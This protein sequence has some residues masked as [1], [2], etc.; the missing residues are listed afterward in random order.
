MRTL[1]SLFDYTGEWSAPFWHA[2]WDVIQ[3]D[4]QH[5]TDISDFS[6]EYLIDN[7]LGDGTVD[8]VILAPPCTEFTVSGAR[9]WNDK[10]ADGRTAAAAELVLQGI[11][12]I[13]F[14]KPDF[15]A[16]ENPP[17]RIEKVVEA[18][19]GLKRFTFDPCDFAGYVDRL[20][21]DDDLEAS[22]REKALRAAWDTITA[23]E[24]ELTKRRNLYTKKTVLWGHFPELEKRREEPVKVCAA[25]SWLMRLGGAS[26]E[27]KNARSATPFGFSEAFFR[28]VEDYRLDWE[29]IDNG[30]ELYHS[31]QE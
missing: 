20:P 11:R 30:D 16:L 3:V 23:S 15:W 9:W 14:L 27:T 7:V 13:E 12:T 10:D 28:A 31:F 18:L 17:G 29:A 19:K 25:G 5:G 2:G 21:G 22:V 1:L 6:C 26:A 24:I 4:L 8:G